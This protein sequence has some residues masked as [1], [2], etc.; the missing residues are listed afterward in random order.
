MLERGR[1]LEVYETSG[2]KVKGEGTYACI[3]RTSHDLG[4]RLCSEVFGLEHRF[5]G[6]DD[7]IEPFQELVLL[8]G[9]EVWELRGMLRALRSITIAD[10]VQKHSKGT[11]GV[12]IDETW[13][14][15]LTFP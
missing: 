11:Y 8:T 5:H 2:I 15:K 7:V 6:E 1:C 13:N 9:S 3:D 4:I 10:G 14:Q 12:C